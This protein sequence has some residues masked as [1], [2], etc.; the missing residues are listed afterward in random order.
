MFAD[1]IAGLSRPGKTGEMAVV[2]DT[3]DRFLGLGWYDATSPLRVRMLHVGSPVT[4]D[5]AW[6]RQR[7]ETALSIR[8]KRFDP[9][10]TGWR[11]IHGENDGWPG[12]VLDRYGPVLVLKLYTAAWLPWLDPLVP[13]LQ[14]RLAPAAIVLRLSRNMAIEAEKQGRRDGTVIAGSLPGDSSPVLFEEHGLLFEA[15]VLRGQKTGF[16]L[17]QRENRVRVESLARGR[18]VLNTFAYTGGFSLYAARGGALI[19][20]SL[21]SNPR[22]LDSARRNFERNRG[23]RLPRDAGHELIRADAFEWLAAP[24]ASRYDLIVLDPPALAQRAEDRPSALQGYEHLARNAWKRLRPGGILAAAS[25][26]AQVGAKDFFQVVQEA[27]RE[28]PRLA[29]VLETTGQPADHP[30]CFPEAAYLKC[31]YLLKA[32]TRR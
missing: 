18:I 5:L 6:W 1:S 27:T 7:L 26:S 28:G 23:L 24:G 30:A 21:D 25:C 12:W 15:D 32:G 29:R 13:L 2:Y 10:T 31:I 8:E 17:D 9:S 14:E 20:E 19:V 11:W 16:F 22:A 3:R 4:I